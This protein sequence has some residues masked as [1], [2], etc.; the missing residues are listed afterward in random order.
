M[1]EVQKKNCIGDNGMVW[2]F[3]RGELDAYGTQ[4]D[5]VAAFINHVRTKCIKNPVIGANLRA[6][7]KSVEVQMHSLGRVKQDVK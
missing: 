5:V 6:A 7:M 1:Y 4:V 2:F 3:T